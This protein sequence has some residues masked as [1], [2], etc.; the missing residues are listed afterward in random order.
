MFF[1][2]LVCW[3]V[4]ASVLLRFVALGSGP[5]FGLSEQVIRMIV[6][7]PPGGGKHPCRGW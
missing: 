4:T 2:K 7:F 6:P 1:Y 5:N 3:A